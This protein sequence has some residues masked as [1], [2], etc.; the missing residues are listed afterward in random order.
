LQVFLDPFEEELLAQKKAE[1]HR[2]SAEDLEVCIRS[3][4]KKKECSAFPCFFS[5]N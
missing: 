4:E 3:K 5:N 2:Q 1:Q